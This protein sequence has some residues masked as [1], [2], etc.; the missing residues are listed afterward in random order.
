MLPGSFVED[1]ARELA[2]LARVTV[3]AAS[4]TSSVSESGELTVRRFA[5]PRLPL[6]LLKAHRPQDWL[7]IVTTL[8]SGRRALRDLIA[9]DPPD[10][11]FALWA[12]PCGWWARTE[13]LP[14]RVPY[15]TWALGSDIWTLGRIPV[16]KRQLS[17]VLNDA[18][19]RYAD[20]I[21]LA[22]DVERL[23]GKTCDFLPSARRLPACR[24]R[25]VA[26]TPPY[27]LAFLGRWHPNKGIDLLLD[28]LLGLDD[29]DWQKIDAIRIFGGG[30]L[31]SDVRTACDLL[32]DSGRPVT[33]GGYLDRDA[34]ARLIAWADYLLLPSRIESVPV[35]LSDALQLETPIVCTPVGDLPRLY[36]QNPIGVI[37]D[38]ATARSFRSAIRSALNAPAS[39]F[40]GAVR[41]TGKVFDVSGAARR[42]LQDVTAIAG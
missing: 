31:E 42:F 39:D 41:E 15:S 22:G 25:S 4:R 34:A 33:V 37:A 9:S 28:A 26:T 2:T 10:H 35:I 13:A 6:S 5:V 40:V 14:R 11:V 17:A 16:I 12:L 23:S 24:E 1:F 27:K 19:L 8:R 29:D 7:P 36:A 38:A 18:S 3:L 20:G 32:A 30:P 21:E